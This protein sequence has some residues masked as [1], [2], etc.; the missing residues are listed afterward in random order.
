MNCPA[1]KNKYCT[2]CKL[3]FHNPKTCD[4]FISEQGMTE[5]EKKFRILMK[6]EGWRECPVCKQVVT[7]AGGCNFIRCASTVCNSKNCFCYL[8]GDLLQEK[9]HYDHYKDKDPFGP[10]CLTMVAKEKEGPKDDKKK[11]PE[12]VKENKKIA[13]PKCRADCF[14]EKDFHENLFFCN[15]CEMKLFCIN[16]K[17]NV[18]DDTFDVHIS[19]KCANKCII[20]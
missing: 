1:C 19:A 3:A 17:Q 14:Q 4:E 13:C 16:C 2:R 5:D 8:C 20:F 7:R 11:V 9:D 10:V 6:N 12:P 18:K 15:N